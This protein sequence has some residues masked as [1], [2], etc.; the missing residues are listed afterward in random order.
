MTP[1]SPNE[2][3]TNTQPPALEPVQESSYEESFI[4]LR[5]CRPD[6]GLAAI[7]EHRHAAEEYINSCDESVLRGAMSRDLNGCEYADQSSFHGTT[8]IDHLPKQHSIR[9]KVSCSGLSTEAIQ[10]VSLHLREHIYDGSER[11][12]P[13]VGS[14]LVLDMHA[15]GSCLLIDCTVPRAF[16]PGLA[17]VLMLGKVLTTAIAKAHCCGQLEFTLQ[18][19]DQI[20]LVKQCANPYVEVTHVDV[21]NQATVVHIGYSAGSSVP[22]DF[23]HIIT[24]KALKPDL[25]FFAILVGFE[26][27]EL[28]IL[29]ADES[30]GVYK[31]LC[32]ASLQRRH[33]PFTVEA[34]EGGHRSKPHVVTSVQSSAPVDNTGVSGA[35]R[36]EA[37]H[38]SAHPHRAVKCCGCLQQEVPVCLTNTGE[39]A[40]GICWVCPACT[41][42]PPERLIVLQELANATQT[43][44]N[45][46]SGVCAASLA[47]PVAARLVNRKQ[48]RSVLELDKSYTGPYMAKGQDGAAERLVKEVSLDN[49]DKAY[50]FIDPSR[51][52]DAVMVTSSQASAN[53]D[54]S[55]AVDGQGTGC[56]SRKRKSGLAE[57]ASVSNDDFTFPMP[58][59]GCPS[60]NFPL[61]FNRV[62]T[63]NEQHHCLSEAAFDH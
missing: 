11:L 60:P 17:R 4:L 10:A 36:W 46:Q 57:T 43:S 52:C 3:L 59:I 51:N 13:G 24:A 35:Q 14:G 15:A 7:P 6:T 39:Q 28:K 23:L 48:K 20:A 61:A 27:V 53:I 58:K 30:V 63:G 44:T 62:H 34:H 45:D 22:N 47:K 5:C 1:G 2:L 12:S 9:G 38:S 49:Q 8:A 42:N 21:D 54:H 55:L 26:A 56:D 41:H 33:T 37:C 31:V 29:T 18:L 40:S 32:P 19:N 16:V 25:G 50:K